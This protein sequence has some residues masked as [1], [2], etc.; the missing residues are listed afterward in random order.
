MQ[1]MKFSNYFDNRHSPDLK[2]E[3]RCKWQTLRHNEPTAS[4]L[5]DLSVRIKPIFGN[6][7]MDPSVRRHYVKFQV[8]H[9]CLS[10]PLDILKSTV[11]RRHPTSRTS[12]P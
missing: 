7:D 9:L 11:L 6:T 8:L 12:T 10:Q 2:G 4:E 3:I 1:R 5:F